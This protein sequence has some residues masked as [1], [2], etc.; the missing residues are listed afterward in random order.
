MAEIDFQAEENMAKETE[1]AKMLRA[2]REKLQVTSEEMSTMLGVPAYTAQLARSYELEGPPRDAAY[3][4]TAARAH[5]DRQEEE[6]MNYI[7]AYIVLALRD[8]C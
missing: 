5:P 8:Y 3:R 1:Q 7:A 4:E 2:A 6:S